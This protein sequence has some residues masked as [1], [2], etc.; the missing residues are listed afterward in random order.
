M[1]SHATKVKADIARWVERGLIDAATARTLADDVAEHD[2]RGLSFGTILMTLAALLMA[3]ALLLVVASNWEA[4]PRIARV[5]ALFA[6]IVGGYVG[7][8]LIRREDQ[9]AVSEALWLIA[10]AAFGGSIALIGQMY[11]MSGDEASAILTWCAGTALAAAVLRSG[12]LTVAATAIAAFWMVMENFEFWNDHQNSYLYLP[13]ALVLWLVS[14]W[15]R[16]SASRHL[17]LLSLVL[18]AGTFAFDGAALAASAITVAVAVIAF[19]AA[20]MAPERTERFAMLNGRLPLHA[21]IAFLAGLGLFQIEL[22]SSEPVLAVSSLVAFGAI[23]AALVLAGRESR[24][25]RWIAY[26]GFSLQLALLYTVTVGTM[27]GTAGMF[28]LAGVALA[29]VAYLIMRIERR[30][31]GPR[32][33]EGSLAK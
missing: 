19:T 22:S 20:I 13:L 8:A 4:I 12:P 17:I 33:L 28:L 31:S 29:A 18:Y 25:L 30:M 3:A 6:V 15:T 1:A 23:A 32:A 11:H 27:L 21:L 14:I 26:L 24:G 5:V 2:R 16:S 10:A 9:T 7:G